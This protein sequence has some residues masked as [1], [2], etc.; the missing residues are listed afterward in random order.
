M[1][2]HFELVVRSESLARMAD[3]ASF[4]R[5]MVRVVSSGGVETII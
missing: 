2:S 3:I 5:V 1:Q 4:E